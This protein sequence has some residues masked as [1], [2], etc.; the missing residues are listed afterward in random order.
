MLDRPETVDG[1]TYKIKPPIIDDAIYITIND[2]EVAGQVRPVE[3]FINSKNMDSFQWI[4]LI[5]RLASALMRTSDK[6]PYFI[7]DE[8]LET[9]DPHGDYVVPKT[10]GRRANSIIAHIGMV[11]EDHCKELGIEREPK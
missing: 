9:F 5:T 11:L 4:S 8:M 10:K 6:F 1:K 7:I 2:A 3:I